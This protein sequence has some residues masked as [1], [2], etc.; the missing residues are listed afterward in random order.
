MSKLIDIRGQEFGI[1][2]P[3]TWGPRSTVVPAGKKAGCSDQ[4]WAE[5]S[6]IAVRLTESGDGGTIKIE[7]L[8]NQLPVATGTLGR[9]RWDR[10]VR[11][12]NEKSGPRKSKPKKGHRGWAK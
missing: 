9:W 6:G 12:M 10:L 5:E 2:I 11:A 8:D 3:T 1:L 4:V 7:I